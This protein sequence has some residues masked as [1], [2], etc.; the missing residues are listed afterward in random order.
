MQR[1]AARMGKSAVLSPGIHKDLEDPL[2]ANTAYPTDPEMQ[3]G[4]FANLLCRM[5][6]EDH[7]V[8]PDLC[9]VPGQAVLHASCLEL[10]SGFIHIQCAFAHSHGCEGGVLLIWRAWDPRL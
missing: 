2:L 10:C 9:D 8:H 4:M 3:L 6:L 5:Q 7:Q 1:C